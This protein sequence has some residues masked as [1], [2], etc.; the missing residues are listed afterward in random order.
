MSTRNQHPEI[1]PCGK[2]PYGKAPGKNPAPKGDGEFLPSA[3]L[4]R[5]RF[6]Q[7]P[8]STPIKK[9]IMTSPARTRPSATRILKAE[10]LF[11][12][13]NLLIIGEAR[14]EERTLHWA[15]N[16]AVPPQPGSSP[17][18]L[19]AS[20]LVGIAADYLG[21]PVT[22][23]LTASPAPPRPVPPQRPE[24]VEAVDQSLLLYDALP[25]VIESGDFGYFFPGTA[26]IEFVIL[27]RIGRAKELTAHL[28][29]AGQLGDLPP[30]HECL[31]LPVWGAS[32]YL[33]ELDR[34]TGDE[35]G[36]VAHV[37]VEHH[38]DCPIKSNGH[39]CRCGFL[40]V[41]AIGDQEWSVDTDGSL[42]ALPA[43]PI[44]F[45]SVRR[46]RPGL[47]DWG[48]GLPEFCDIVRKRGL[49]Y[50]DRQGVAF[51]PDYFQIAFAGDLAT[52]LIP[53]P[54]PTADDDE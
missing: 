34:E 24:P 42:A 35:A 47:S 5:P 10:W 46:Y 8:T 1:F 7:V 18:I 39:G 53:F 40:L 17:P 21:H 50:W 9:Q 51:V 30:L 6:F 32:F 19:D 25:S 16:S 54:L 22:L 29:A 31:M 15:I 37:S 27:R 41:I 28:T 23:T 11:H 44:R 52:E 14:R 26:G 36:P 49:V 45:G 13:A 38:R 3:C 12:R 48:R 43:L 33:P 2:I 20:R 4:C